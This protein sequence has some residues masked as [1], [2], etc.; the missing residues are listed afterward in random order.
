MLLGA[1]DTA[2]I[3]RHRKTGTADQSTPTQTMASGIS[4]SVQPVRSDD[5]TLFNTDAPGGALYYVFTPFLAVPSIVN[6][7]DVVRLASGLD[8][9]ISRVEE[10]RGVMPHL[11]LVTRAARKQPRVAA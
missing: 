5:P 7:G 9:T 11:K 2:D 4:V 1:N 3:L 8:L 6:D 10:H